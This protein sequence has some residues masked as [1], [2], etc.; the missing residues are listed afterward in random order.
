MSLDLNNQFLTKLLNVPVL[1]DHPQSLEEG[2][3]DLARTTAQI[4]N[5]KRCSVML[6][7]PGDEEVPAGLR[8]CS[9]FGDLPAAAYAHT[10]PLDEGI[11]GYVFRSGEPVLIEDV[12]RSGF[13]ANAH[14]EPTT[15]PSLLASP[16]KIA[17]EVIGVINLSRPLNRARFSKHDLE[18][19]EIFSLVVGLAIQVFQLQKLAESHLL[20]MAEVL[21]RREET[22]T[23]PQPISPDPSRLTKMV[24]KNFYRELSAAG[25]GQKDIIAV[26]TQVLAQLSDNISKHRTRM[27][28]EQAR[29][30]T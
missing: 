6:F 22:Q 15:S 10:M 23:T 7:D 29:G 1:L 2:L 28:R 4:L 26:A 21:R 17:N 27:E 25:F 8:V 12:Y 20:Q 13:A 14:Q 16:I 11:A 3:R 19:L 18:L 24:A 9:H 5:A 30:E